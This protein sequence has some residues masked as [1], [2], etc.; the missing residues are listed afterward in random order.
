MTGAARSVAD[1]ARPPVT[2][3]HRPAANQRV[4]A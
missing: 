3:A 4:P 1:P 2:G